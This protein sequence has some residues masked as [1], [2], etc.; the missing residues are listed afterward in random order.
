MCLLGDVLFSREK[1]IFPWI[2]EP[3]LLV[4]LAQDAV[5][6]HAASMRPGTKVLVDDVMVTDISPFGP[7][8]KVYRASLMSMADSLGVRKC[9]NI[10]ALGAVAGSPGCLRSIKLHRPFWLGHRVAPT[11][12]GKP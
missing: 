1:I 3:E 12:T 6:A 5:R 8:V 7:E 9:T 2:L 4:A 10:V 11:S